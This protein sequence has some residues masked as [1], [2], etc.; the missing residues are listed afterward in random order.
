MALPWQRRENPIPEAP[1]RRRNRRRERLSAE[2]AQQQ[3]VNISIRLHEER[4]RQRLAITIGSMLILA[5]LA[6][7]AV[8]YYREFFEPPRVT[9][10]EIRGVKYTM[11][12]L[13]ERIRVLQGI[14]RYQGG[15]VDLS[16]VPFQ[17]LRRWR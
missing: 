8:G 11:G 4:R 3:S 1:G 7:V 16:V 13:V 9:A 14:N 5:I 6:I 10:G 12:D 17:Y 15:F 2:Q